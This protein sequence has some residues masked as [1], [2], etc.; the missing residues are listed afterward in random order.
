MC[1]LTE[2]VVIHKY[3]LLLTCPHADSP[4]SDRVAFEK[5]C[6]KQSLSQQGLT[7]HLWCD[8]ELYIGIF[9]VLKAGAAYIP[10]DPEYPADRLIIMAEDS[11]V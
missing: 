4:C 2:K 1:K 8:A 3:M 5:G 9:A 6:N 11:E 7:A 10:M